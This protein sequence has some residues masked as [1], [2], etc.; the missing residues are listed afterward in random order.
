VYLKEHPSEAA[1]KGIPGPGSYKIASVTGNEGA[2]F[3]MRPKTTNHRLISTAR[4]VPGPGAYDFK[5]S[6]SNQNS[7]QIGWNSKLR[8]ASVCTFN[9]GK[10]D[11]FG[12]SK[13]PSKQVPGPGQY[14][15]KME[16]SK[17][18]DYFFSKYTSAGTRTFYHSNRQTIQ[19]PTCAKVTPGPGH[20][21]PPSEF[22]Y[23]EPRKKFV[24]TAKGGRRSTAPRNG[25]MK[26]SASQPDLKKG[27][28]NEA[29]EL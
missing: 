13:N 14:S 23:Y 26:G 17:T 24:K 28:D 20:Y 7:G 8:S 10:G 27:E 2:K 21:R 15:P 22:G 12:V 1:T 9:K 18:G 25:G 4:D 19:L 6:V 3:S 16:M 29:K 11:R 5:A